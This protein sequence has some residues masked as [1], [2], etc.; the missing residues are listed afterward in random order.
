[1]D[2]AIR[3]LQTSADFDRQPGPGHVNI[4]KIA[5]WSYDMNHL[6]KH[7]LLYSMTYLTLFFRQIIVKQAQLK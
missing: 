5:G 2:N 6:F 3:N 4:L 7:Y 1:M